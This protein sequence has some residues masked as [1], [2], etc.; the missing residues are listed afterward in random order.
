MN[1]LRHTLFPLFLFAVVWTPVQANWTASGTFHYVNR[2]LDATGFTGVETPL[3]IRAA[4]V[5][6]VDANASGKKAVLAT[7]VTDTQGA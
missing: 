1:R 2:E 3:P 7:G 5:E 6:V 4:D